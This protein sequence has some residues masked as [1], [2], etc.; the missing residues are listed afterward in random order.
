MTKKGIILPQ[1]KLV[2]QSVNSQHAVGERLE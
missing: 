1:T 2:K